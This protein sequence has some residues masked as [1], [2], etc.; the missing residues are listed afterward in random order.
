MEKIDLILWIISGGFGITFALMLIIWNSLNKKIDDVN[1]SLS[2]KIDDVDNKL[3]NRID[4]L[5][6]KLTDV[7]RRLC[8][9]EGAFSSKDCCILKEDRH[10]KRAE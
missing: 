8:R 6:E 9:M 5:D 3:S 10:I 2:K 4:K 1:T 7:D